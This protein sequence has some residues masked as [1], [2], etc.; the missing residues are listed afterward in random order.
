MAPGASAGRGPR[1]GPSLTGR[2]WEPSL[3]LLCDAGWARWSA[4]SIRCSAA[5]GIRAGSTGQQRL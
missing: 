5:Q 2:G 1:C 4:E 3:V